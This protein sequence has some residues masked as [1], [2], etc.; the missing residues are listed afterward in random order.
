MKLNKINQDQII[1]VN[2]GI[3]DNLKEKKIYI[4]FFKIN[5]IN[6]TMKKRGNTFK[7]E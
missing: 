7:E 4:Y 3:C 2:N 5:R 6:E 1:F